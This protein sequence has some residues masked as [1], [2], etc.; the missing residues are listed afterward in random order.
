MLTLA[1]GIGIDTAIFS[2]AKE[3][4]RPSLPFRESERLVRIYQVPEGSSVRVSPRVPAF[5]AVRDG[6][7]SLESV[8]GSRFS[9]F[10]LHTPDGPERLVGNAVTAGWLETLGV[11]PALGRDFT[12]DEEAAG[13]GSGVVLVSHQVWR[14]RLGGSEDA[15]GSTLRLNGRPHVVVGVLPPGFHFP[16]DA[17]LWV[18]LRPTEADAGF[19]ALN[20]PAR[21]KPGVS[22]AAARADLAALTERV[23]PT[24]PGFTPGT[25]FTAVPIR[26]VMVE[27][28]GRTVLALAA[29]VGFL[30]LV[31]CANLANLLLARAL[32]RES[33]FAVRASLGASRG[34]LVRQSLVEST[35]LGLI[36][37]ALGL[38]VAYAAVDFLG[39]LLPGDFSYLGLGVR[40]DVIALVFA[41]ALSIGTGLLMGILPA[42]RGSATNPA[43]AMREGGRSGGSRRRAGVGRGLVVA[44]LA[45]TLVLLTGVGLMVRDVQRQQALDL[46]YEA[47]GLLVFSVPL[48]EAPYETGEARMAFAQRLLSELES[49]PDV[50]TAGAVN[51]FPRHQGN[52]LAEVV[53]EGREPAPGERL[54]VNYRLVSAGYLESLGVPLL[55]GRM[56][57]KTDQAGTQLVGLVSASLAERLWPGEDPVGKRVR[58]QRAGQDVPWV[59]VVGVV[60][61]VR[62]SDD[63]LDS[64]YVPFAQAADSR[65][66]RQ[67]AVVARGPWIP[68][69]P[70]SALPLPAP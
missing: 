13:E 56:I 3:T 68:S 10:T 40:L 59:T 42:L 17:H 37:G 38:G 8:V 16:Y 1:L 12:P 58:D 20:I 22:V 53:P 30:L 9:N 51:L 36:G 34:R 55:R 50:A 6:A 32:A 18:P 44:E 66:A 5:I 19:W 65:F 60:G 57:A 26:E 35:T 29:A 14:T 31:V 62:Q 11:Q 61:D 28:E 70:Y 46:G 67:L 4:L 41:A 49:R 23:A 33:E 54:A 48:E 52:T 43:D 7:E 45:V 69:F 39:F 24:L 64:W 25:T 27:D 47:Q 15:V 2:A 63:V 21:L